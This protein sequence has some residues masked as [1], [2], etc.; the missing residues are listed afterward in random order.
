ML[1]V[2]GVLMLIS[3]IFVPSFGIL[4]ILGIISLGSG[5]VLA[6]QNTGQGL[7]TL[8]I[9]LV[10]GAVIIAIVVKYFSHRGIWHRFILKDALTEEKK[11]YSSTSPKQR[12]LHQRGASLTP[13]RP[14]GTARIGEERVDV[15]T[16]GEFIPSGSEIEVI[17]VEGARVVVKAI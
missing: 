7:L 9:A 11:G 14:A 4:G 15:V 5:I 6:A 2:A 16:R 10:I 17:E 3:E 1:F 8:T 13:L 12:F